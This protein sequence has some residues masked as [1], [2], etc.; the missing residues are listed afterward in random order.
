MGAEHLFAELARREQESALA[1]NNDLFDSVRGCDRHDV[2]CGMAAGEALDVAVRSL[3]GLCVDDKE[4]VPGIA[5]LL[6]VLPPVSV[7]DD[8]QRTSGE[9]LVVGE[10]V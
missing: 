5:L 3:R 6:V 4:I 2:A 10:E 9:A 7:K 8:N 1:S